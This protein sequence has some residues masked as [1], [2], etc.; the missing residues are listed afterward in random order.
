MGKIQTA[1]NLAKQIAA[2]DS[3]GYLWGGNGPVDFDCSGLV[4]YVWTQAGVPVNAE[5]RNTTYTMKQYYTKHGFSDVTNQVNLATGAGLQAGD[6][7]VNTANHT[8]ICVGNGRIV[9]A[10]TNMDGKSGDSSG[11]EIREQAYYNFNPW[12][13]VLRYTG[14]GAGA[15]GGAPGSARPTAGTGEAAGG[16]SPAPTISVSVPLLQQGTKGGYV[17]ALQLLLIGRGTRCGP[18]GADGDFGA[19]T[20]GGVMSWQRGHGLEVDG[21]AGKQTWES[22]LKG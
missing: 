8:A 2:D 22:L 10:R 5:V 20:K 12:N 14:E 21:V 1:V 17:K 16:A 19:G 11:Q 7:L 18:C 3:H 4:N 6:V 15:S 13:T 9:Q